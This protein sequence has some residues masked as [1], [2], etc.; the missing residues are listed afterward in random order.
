M[1]QLFQ[2][3]FIAHPRSVDETYM[4]HMRFAGSF[5]GRLFLAA[6]AATVHAVLPCFFEKTA[7][8]I[9]KDIHADLIG[10]G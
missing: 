7:S 5:A 8:T 1:T 2:R 9:I 4:Q 6:S 10:R 3:I